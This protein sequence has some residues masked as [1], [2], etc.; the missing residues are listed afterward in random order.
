MPKGRLPKKPA[1]LEPSAYQNVCK[2]PGHSRA[3]KAR[4][5]T[6][7]RHCRGSISEAK[8]IHDAFCVGRA[9]RG[10]AAVVLPDEGLGNVVSEAVFVKY[11][12]PAF[13]VS[14]AEFQR[15]VD[16]LVSYYEKRERGM[17]PTATERLHALPFIQTRVPARTKGSIWLFQNPTRNRDPFAGVLDEWLGHRLG[18]NLPAAPETHLTFGFQAGH[19]DELKRPTFADVGWAV[20]PQWHWGG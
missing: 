14:V 11:T 12:A 13:R 18:L 2:S 5:L 19:V 6:D 16:S 4:Y 8:L 20:L 3:E 9:R 1:V 17:E 7:L 15:R 10:P